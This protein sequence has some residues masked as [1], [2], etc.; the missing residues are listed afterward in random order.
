VIDLDDLL[1]DFIDVEDRVRALEY[2]LA[3][4][5]ALAQE[6]RYSPDWWPKGKVLD[7]FGE[8]FR[9]PWEPETRS[10]RIDTQT[11]LYVSLY[12]WKDEAEPHVR[13]GISYRLPG[14]PKAALVRQRKT[15]FPVGWATAAIS[16][17][18]EDLY[19]RA[20]SRALLRRRCRLDRRG[21]RALTY[22]ETLG[23]KVR[24]LEEANAQK[25][26]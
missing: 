2:R 4:V 15:F 8:T 20:V 24:K 18:W 7:W 21:A 3:N 10:F 5:E 12:R 17:T 1:N 11:T 9:G 19:R 13:C 26:K 23:E 22:I 6:Y 14:E 16:G 25:E